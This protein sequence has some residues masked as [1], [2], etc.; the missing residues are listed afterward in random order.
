MI[1]GIIY[2]GLFGDNYLHDL[3]ENIKG[4]VLPC[5]CGATVGFLK[6]LLP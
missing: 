5:S 3:V 2:R 6:V 1:K 4:D